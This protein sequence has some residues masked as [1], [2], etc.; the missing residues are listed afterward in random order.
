MMFVGSKKRSTPTTRKTSVDRK[1]RQLAV[2]S[3]FSAQKGI[4]VDFDNRAM[5]R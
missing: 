1:Q 5:L 3:S 2:N 4:G